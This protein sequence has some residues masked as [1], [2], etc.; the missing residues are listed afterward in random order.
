M[1]FLNSFVFLPVKCKGCIGRFFY[2]LT[3][4]RKGLIYSSAGQSLQREAMLRSACPSLPAQ[5]AWWDWEQGRMERPVLC[6]PQL[7]SP[8]S[9]HWS[10]I[11]LHCM[12]AR[13]SPENSPGLE[14]L[15]AFVEKTVSWSPALERSSQ[16]T[17]ISGRPV[18]Y[19]VFR[20][21]QLRTDDHD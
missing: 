18:S 10:H 3:T 2:L 8:Y 1:Y 9:V 13:V 6:W 21:T 11:N 16:N 17:E 15:C 14:A 12:R 19:W 7:A 20:K 4:Q 5:C